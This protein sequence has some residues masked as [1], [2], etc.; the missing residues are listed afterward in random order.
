MSAFSNGPGPG[1]ES[2]KCSSNSCN[3]HRQASGITESPRA[4]SKALVF[5]ESYSASAQ[6]VHHAIVEY[7]EEIL[8]ALHRCQEEGGKSGGIL[9][10]HRLVDELQRAAT[11]ANKPMIMGGD[12][13]RLAQSCQEVVVSEPCMGLALRPIIGM[14]KYIRI[15]INTLTI[16]ELSVSD[17]LSFK[18]GLTEAGKQL[19]A[20]ERLWT[21][22]VDLEPFNS[23]F[24]HMSRP[25]SIGDGVRFLN[26]HLSSRL[27]TTPHATFNPVCDF[28][29]TLQT[30]GDPL[31]VGKRITDV[32]AMQKAL[33]K[34]E[35]LL[36]RCDAQAPFA[37]VAAKLQEIGLERG[38]GNTV[39]AALDTMHL[40]G[41]LLQAPDAEL[42]QEFLGRLPIIFNVA[43]LSPHG[44]FGQKDVLGKPDTGGQVVYILDMVRALEREM[45]KRIH[46]QGLNMEPQI[47]V[48]TRL[49]PEALG[50][51]C[52][53]RIERIE[54]TEHAKILRVPF[55]SKAGILRKWI[56]RFE[57]YPYLE[58]FTMDVARELRKE[59]GG[60]PDFIIGNYS[61]GNLVASL[62]SSYLNT[63]MCTIAHALEKTKYPDADVHW[64]K[65]D[66]QY[67][68]S[69]QFT[70]DLIAMN[71]SDFIITSTFQEIAGDA[72]TVGQYESHTAFTMPGLYRVVK[73][74][75]VFDP[76][77][78]IVS[79]GA[80]P[81]VYFPFYE[82]DRRLT[83][84]HP[85]IV[86]LLFGS[87]EAPRAKGVLKDKKKP[88]L[89]SMAR[90]DRV[91]NLTGL[92]E[93]YAKSDRLRA[94]CNLVIVG[95]IVDPSQTKDV[96]EKE[97]CERMHALIKEYK[98][99]GQLRWLVAQKDRVANGE[100]YRYIADTRGAFVQ[101]ALY[102]AFGLTV[103]EAMTCGLPCFATNRGGPAEIIKNGLSGYHIDP[104]HPEEAGN[105][106]ADFFEAAGDG[107]AWDKIS[108]A[109]L[110]RIRSRYTWEIYAERLMTLSR[111][112]SFWKYVKKLDRRE[113]R[114]YLEMFYILRLRPL[115]AQMKAAQ[116]DVGLTEAAGVV[117][118]DGD[119][120]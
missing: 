50:T 88:I 32:N 52:N 21:L 20:R 6:D 37:T 9:L 106:M 83:K 94:V 36:L 26:R 59:L 85:G 10:P 18:E 39:G 87:D 72:D 114:R 76:K 79:P 2:I 67:H 75:D 31:M 102:E 35:Q 34:A 81:E 95:G 82:A 69:C 38:W 16:E 84:L 44:F 22:E 96:E 48:I 55:R 43:I 77:F 93:L 112:Y 118:T 113:A 40:L 99:E 24:P 46:A 64:K 12:F 104:Y 101:P 107:S 86:D 91:K 5:A 111:V 51:S 110:E 23:S 73:G 19:D 117:Q 92:A 68:F 103:I 61:D 49:I 33:T 41:E 100:L 3:M 66:S 13:A 58:Q 105:I 42:L 120:K 54:G 8:E 98:L 47:I 28:L 57:V 65:L 7:R 45:L 4:R 89:F 109:G 115:I 70:A 97:Q 25:S 78:N 14:W 53:Q 27:F 119:A 60:R 17:Y 11:K 71:A 80:D 56:S 30:N 62:L 90:L 63:T 74:V 29:R 108:R 15:C 1:C 116:D